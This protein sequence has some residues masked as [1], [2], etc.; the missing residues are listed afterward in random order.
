MERHHGHHADGRVAAAILSASGGS[1]ALEGLDP[2]VYEIYVDPLDHPVSSGNLGGGQVIETDFES[3]GGQFV[4]A[5]IPGLQDT[6][7]LARAGVGQRI[8]LAPGAVFRPNS[9]PSAYLRFN[10]ATSPHPG[11]ERFLADQLERID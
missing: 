7:A 10:V 3:R 5:R 9:Q 11:L 1:F 6:T 8:I 4:W 2:G